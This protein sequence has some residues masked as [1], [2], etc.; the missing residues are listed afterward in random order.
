MREIGRIKLVQVQQAPLKKGTRPN[1]WYDPSPLRTVSALR[2][3]PGGVL[4][5]T[6]SGEQII[7]AHNTAFHEKKNSGT[8]GISIGFTSH[9][10]AMVRK[11]GAHLALG[12][13]GENI[14]VE[15]DP[16]IT[17][18]NLGATLLI[19]G[20]D[21][22]S[23]VL[24]NVMVAAPCLEFSRYADR[25]AASG[26]DLKSTVQFLNNGMRGFYATLAAGQSDADIRA[27]DLLFSKITR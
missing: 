4:G 18:E 10:A 25:A 16:M 17:L 8:N 26:S 13:A 14:I 27:G 5:L 20:A 24:D 19:K 11:F 9:Y 12:C 2:L 1:R 6:E 3:Q 22:R 23:V 7:D 21:G 15:S